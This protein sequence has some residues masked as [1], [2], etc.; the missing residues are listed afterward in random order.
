[1]IFE[2]VGQKDKWVIFEK[3]GNGVEFKGNNEYHESKI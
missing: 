1:M 2:I 3:D